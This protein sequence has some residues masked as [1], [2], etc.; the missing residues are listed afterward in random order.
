MSPTFRTFVCNHGRNRLRTRLGLTGVPFA[1][2][3][4]KV[5]PGGCKVEGRAKHMK[6]AT[7]E[8]RRRQPLFSSHEKNRP[9]VLCTSA[10]RGQR[11]ARAP[12][13]K[14]CVV[15][16][17]CPS[18]RPS[19]CRAAVPPA[20]QWRPRAPAAAASRPVI[21]K[22]TRVTT[23]LCQRRRCHRHVHPF[24]PGLPHGAN[25]MWGE[26]GPAVAGELD[27]LHRAAVGA[28]EVQRAD[29]KGGRAIPCNIRREGGE[30][31]VILEWREENPL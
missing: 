15:T 4:R 24:V 27:F 12:R 20:P 26:D 6:R 8:K 23:C 17:T 3:V 19:P 25:G 2:S 14:S 5:L 31:L 30:S 18:R 22:R 10:P 13:D 11:L 9:R 29:L 21:R 16:R 28:G 1:A 7:D